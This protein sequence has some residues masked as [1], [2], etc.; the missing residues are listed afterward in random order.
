MCLL[1]WAFSFLLLAFYLCKL[2]HSH[3]QWQASLPEKAQARLSMSN[4][5]Q[6][7]WRN[8]FLHD[9]C[10]GKFCPEGSTGRVSFCM[11]QNAMSRLNCL[12]QGAGPS[13]TSQGAGK[14]HFWNTHLFLNTPSFFFSHQTMS[15]MDSRVWAELHPFSSGSQRRSHPR[16][17]HLHTRCHA[18]CEEAPIWSTTAYTLKLAS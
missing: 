6:S 16:S 17:F 1:S 7:S 15:L 5:W 10:K 8:N 18:H 12:M 4:Q 11:A 9:I 2:I 3:F 13:Q 14:R